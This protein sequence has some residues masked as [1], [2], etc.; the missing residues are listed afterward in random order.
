MVENEYPVPS[1]MADVFQKPDD[2]VEI[3]EESEEAKNAETP[4]KIYALDCEMVS[5]S[6][7]IFLRGL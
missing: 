6:F 1:Y 3:P 2:W 4:R 7:H 5:N